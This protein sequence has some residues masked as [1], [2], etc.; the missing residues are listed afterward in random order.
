MND[1]QLLWVGCWENDKEFQAKAKKGYKLAS[2]VISQGNLIRGLEEVTGCTFDSVNGAVTPPYPAY[3]D[4]VITPVIWHHKKGA[5]DIS[6]G[7]ENKKYINRVNCKNAMI[8]AAKKWIR[9]RYKG[10]ELIVLAYSMRSA[11]MAT[12]CYIKRCIPKASIY[13]I[14]TDLP[15]FMDLG[16][17]RIKA[18]LKKIDWFTIKRL[19]PKF[20]GFILYSAKMASFLRIPKGK[21]MLMEGSYD[22]AETTFGELPKK[23]AIMYSGTLDREYGIPMLLEAFMAIDDPEAELWISGGGNAEDH[24]K[25][26]A[27]KDERIKFFGFLPSREDVLELQQQA[28]LLVNMRLPS[29]PASAYCFPSKLFEYMATG[30]PVLSFRLKG[31]PKEY[32]QY[33]IV[34]N[35]ENVDDLKS[36][37]VKSLGETETLSYIGKRAKSFILNEKNSVAQAKRI[38]EY[39]ESSEK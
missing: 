38:I 30:V 21:W 25:A 39:V 29:E 27:G 7:Y 37:L 24:I 2:A 34:V 28:S 20:D 18:A 19:Q 35:N 22:A 26:C 23:K 16:Q 5:F 1:R 10:G 9:D 6:V 8:K 32:Y 33:L 17:N 36:A 12:A 4:K 14:V 11:S 13:L 3:A 31:I 15:H